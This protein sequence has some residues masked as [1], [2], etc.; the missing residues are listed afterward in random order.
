M[1]SHWDFVIYIQVFIV[2]MNGIVIR[3]EIGYL[4]ELIPTKVRHK[5]SYFIKVAFK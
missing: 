1:K 3:D 2:V 4:D 5:K